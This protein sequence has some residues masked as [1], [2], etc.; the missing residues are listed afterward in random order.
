MYAYT[1]HCFALSQ[2]LLNVWGI[3]RTLTQRDGDGKKGEGKGPKGKGFWEDKD[4][5]GKPDGMQ[6]KK[7]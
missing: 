1:S 4:K 6:K 3:C 2:L 7:D 5:N